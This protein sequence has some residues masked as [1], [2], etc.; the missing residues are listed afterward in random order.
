MHIST[1]A[2]IGNHPYATNNMMHNTAHGRARSVDTMNS[3]PAARNRS[4][5]EEIPGILEEYDDTA[6][7]LKE[8]H[9]G[10]LA[11]LAARQQPIQGPSLQILI[12]NTW[13]PPLPWSEVASKSVLVLPSNNRNKKGEQTN[14]RKLERTLVFQLSE[15]SLMVVDS[16]NY[17]PHHHGHR[18][19]NK[20]GSSSSDEHIQST[21]G[22]DFKVKYL[23]VNNDKRVKLTIWDTAGQERCSDALFV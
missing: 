9:A 11:S 6:A 3:P 17:K 13:A 2:P 21:I 18:D 5:T 10:T 7:A 15:F 12:Y 16:H 14:K 20:H 4:S 23:D 22:V 19:K 1:Q 8:D